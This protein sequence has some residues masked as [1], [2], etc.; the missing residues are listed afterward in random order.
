MPFEKN[1]FSAIKATSLLALASVGF[2]ACS[3]S[4]CCIAVSAAS[5]DTK[6]A[7]ETKQAQEQ[8]VAP[9]PV[10]P[11]KYADEKSRLLDFVYLGRFSDIRKTC[12][13]KIADGSAKAYHYQTAALAWLYPTQ[14]LTAKAVRTCQEGL[15]YF[16]D[17]IGLQWT[18]AVS[19]ARN[20][21]WA[22]ALR[23]SIKVLDRDPKN[24][25][26]LAVKAICMHRAGREDPGL[27]V[28][29]RALAVDPG[30]EEL[31]M[32]I[33]FYARMRHKADDMYVA[34]DRWIQLR[35]RSAVALVWRAEYEMDDGR[36]DEALKHFLQAEALN[37]D[38][39]TAIYKIGKLYYNKQNWAA[40][41]KAFMHCE[42]LGSNHSTGV[43]RLGD[44]LLR[45]KRYK[46]A[47][48]VCTTAIEMFKS[49][50]FRQEEALGVPGFAVL[51]ESSLLVESQVKR[52]IAYFYSGDTEKAL[53]DLNTV[54]RE[55]PD[56]VPALDLNQKIA[57]KTG[58]YSGAVAS[59]TKL[60]EIDRDVP[61]WYINRAEAFK[62]LGKQQAAADDLKVV[63]A[64]DKTGK[65]P[66]SVSERNM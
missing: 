20:L 56:N 60:I 45:T 21:Q 39:G 23:Q 53:A 26:A 63:E 37:P 22:P 41:A 2:A 36:P 16:P 64:I 42:K 44:C 32:L 35:P 13:P 34:L 47:V 57:F 49:N 33:V 15:K 9:P 18:F 52:A 17:D 51:R 59:L 48:A 55:H 27:L 31:N 66:E 3:F 43:A 6:K 8:I 62:K 38:Y 7:E 28:L 46:E 50:T 12:D 5:T 10:K 25:P 65:L 61:L 1:K 29:R 4:V 11:I 19:L 40:A 58:N 24:V 30:E 54:L 14:P